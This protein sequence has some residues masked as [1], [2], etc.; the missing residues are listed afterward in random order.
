MAVAAL[1]RYAV[2]DR[3]ATIASSTNLI[4]FWNCKARLGVSV[5]GLLRRMIVFIA[6]SWNYVNGLRATLTSVGMSITRSA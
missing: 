5:Y 1:L 3:G 4:W 2:L 6:I